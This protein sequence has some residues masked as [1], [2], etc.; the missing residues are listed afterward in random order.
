MALYIAASAAVFILLGGVASACHAAGASAGPDSA[1]NAELDVEGR[2][3]APCA[4][5]YG[6]CRFSG[7]RDV[8]ISFQMRFRPARHDGAPDAET[9]AILAALTT[10]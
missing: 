7:T 3:W 10:P 2:K 5:E 4:A 1:S 9:A 8:L 6:T